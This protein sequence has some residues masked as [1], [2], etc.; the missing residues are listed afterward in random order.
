MSK[1]VM[2]QWAEMSTEFIMSRRAIL[3]WDPPNVENGNRNTCM[4]AGKYADDEKKKYLDNWIMRGATVANFNPLWFGEIM[5]SRSIWLQYSGEPCSVRQI[6]ALQEL[7]VLTQCLAWVRL[8]EA[9]VH[10]FSVTVRYYWAHPL[11]FHLHS[12][13]QFPISQRCVSQNLRW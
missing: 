9:M 12:H 11:C 6:A 8:I 7:T 2:I 4:Q 13:P 10:C 5:Y 3:T 1:S